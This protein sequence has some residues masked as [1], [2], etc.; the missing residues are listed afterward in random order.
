MSDTI[1]E[2]RQLSKSYGGRPV[3]HDINLELNR[4]KIIGLLGPNGSGKSTLIKLACGLLTPSGGSI[5]IKGNEP[6]VESKRC[7]SYLPEK[8]YLSDWMRISTIIEFFEDFYSDF[9]KE[10]AYD[11]LKR[12]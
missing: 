4:G 8:T 2:C 6:G 11:M 12:L 10:T 7:V 1:L 5:R 3:L 9:N